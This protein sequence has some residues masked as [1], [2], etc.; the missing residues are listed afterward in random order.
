MNETADAM[1]SERRVERTAINT[2][3]AMARQ[4]IQTI[5]ANDI[6]AV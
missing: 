5:A 2:I 4:A 1:N 3:T 6:A